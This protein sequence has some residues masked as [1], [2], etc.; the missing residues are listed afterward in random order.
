MRSHGWPQDW[1]DDAVSLLRKVWNNYY[2]KDEASRSSTEPLAVAPQVCFY[3]ETFSKPLIKAH[4]NPWSIIEP[5]YQ[6]DRGSNAIDYIDRYLKTPATDVA[7]VRSMGGPIH[8]W[9]HNKKAQPLYRMAIDYLS[10][11][12]KS[13]SPFFACGLD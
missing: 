2:A 11:P 6:H 1:Q 3:Y 9:H 13:Q 7:A 10:A 8:W 12:C 5:D 4:Q